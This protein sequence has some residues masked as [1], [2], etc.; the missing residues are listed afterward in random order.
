MLVRKSAR[1]RAANNAYTVII[2]S[3]DWGCSKEFATATPVANH[4]LTSTRHAAPHTIS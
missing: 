2:P 3:C 1:H 4:R